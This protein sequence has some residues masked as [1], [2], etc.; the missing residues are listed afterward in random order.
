MITRNTFNNKSHFPTII[1]NFK[2]ILWNANLLLKRI[3][4]ALK[5]HSPRL[6]LTYWVRCSDKDLTTAT[7]YF[8]DWP[9]S[10]H[11]VIVSAADRRC[12]NKRY[13]LLQGVDQGNPAACPSGER[14]A[15]LR[16]SVASGLL[17]LSIYK[18]DTSVVVIW[19]IE[20]LFTC[21]PLLIVQICNNIYILIS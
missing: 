9:Y 14:L 10:D 12:L 11:V 2:P 1:L 21:L 16:G 3:V 17:V 4:M 6:M 18:L 7:R 15:R 19:Q 5:E 8:I 20:L 13:H